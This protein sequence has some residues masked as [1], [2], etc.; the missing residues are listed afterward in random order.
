MYANSQPLTEKKYSFHFHCINESPLKLM[1]TILTRTYFWKSALSLYGN[2]YF[3]N[4]IITEFNVYYIIGMTT[5]SFCAVVFRI[6]YQCLLFVP[7][8]I[9]V[10]VNEWLMDALLLLVWTSLNRVWKANRVVK[11]T[12][13]SS[14]ASQEQIN[15]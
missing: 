13:F 8:C 11:L 6:L 2:I 7:S 3:F 9:A 14:R 5:L 4:Y 1:S 10:I 12:F 15:S